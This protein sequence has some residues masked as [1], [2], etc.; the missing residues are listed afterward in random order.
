MSQDRRR[1]HALADVPGSATVRTQTSVRTRVLSCV[2]PCV[3]GCTL[4]VAVPTRALAQDAD[5]RPTKPDSLK[6]K[7]NIAGEFTPAS[8]FDII[9]TDK[10]S[11]NISLYALF[12]YVNQAPDGQTYTD[13][14]GRL[15][16]VGARNDLNW[17]RTM[18]WFSGF[19]FD[20]KLQYTITSWSLATTQQNLI[21]GNIRYV[22][23]NAFVAGVGIAPSLTARSMQGSFPFWAGSDRQMAEEFF[24]GGFSSGVFV[25]GEALP[26]LVY[27]VSIN[28]NISEL[29]VTQANDTR[30][31]LYTGSLRW[32]PTTGEFGPRNGFG[33]LEYH[34]HLA[35]Q[36]GVSA[37]TSRESRYAPLD[38]PPNATQIKLSDGL[39]P[40]TEGSLAPGVT[41]ISLNYHE[42]A[43]DA[44]AKYK[45][46]SFQSEYYL[47]TLDHF[48]ATGPLPITTIFDHGFMAEAMYMVV[49][50]TV[51]I[52]GAGSYIFDDF[53]RHPWEAGGG[54]DFYPAK[55]R[56]W[57]LNLHLLHVDKSP[58]G[59]FFGYYSAGQTGTIFSL[60]TD[61]LF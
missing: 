58:A 20:P 37:A 22:V 43:F 38:Q 53:K 16:T 36:F 13:H 47:R 18:I 9:K 33:D 3:L 32:Q 48:V 39:N 35:T 41:V 51:G 1:S 45:G 28:N 23:S 7:N 46:F 61:I 55:M 21:F 24:R 2:L 49:P 10:G 44:G 12:R 26:R 19:F 29:G 34:E 30:D 40:F 60:G 31:M 25:T 14:L 8:G 56:S 17:H 15:Q 52:Y 57:R 6:F 54:I 11:L 5:L 59:S 42:G 50:R 4:A 27:T